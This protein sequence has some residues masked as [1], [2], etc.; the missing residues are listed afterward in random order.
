MND[1]AGR[2][3]RRGDVRGSAENARPTDYRAN[4]LHAL[5]PILEGNDHTASG[6]QWSDLRRGILGIPE[7]YRKEHRIDRC[8]ARRIIGDHRFGE[9][10]VAVGTAHAQAMLAHRRQVTAAGNEGD[11]VPRLCELRAEIA[12]NASGTHDRNA[13]SIIPSQWDRPRFRGLD[14]STD[15][16]PACT[17][18]PS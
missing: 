18:L 16:F 8:D 3:D 11:I 12:A 5:H 13:H 14:F 17:D 10:D 6:E 2:T 1:D 15:T 9:M 7:L 4:A